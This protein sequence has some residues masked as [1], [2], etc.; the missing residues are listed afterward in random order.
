MNRLLIRRALVDRELK[1]ILIEGESIARIA[2]RIDAAAH[3]DAELVDADGLALLPSLVNAHGHAPMTLLRGIAEDLDLMTWLTR[4]IWPREARLTAEDIYWGLRLAALE[5]IR[6]G[7]TISNEMYFDPR[8]Q[9]R[10]ARDSG[11]RFVVAYPLI[12]GL[13]EAKGAAQRKE[14]AA[15]FDELPDFGP[16]VVFGTAA[17]SVYATSA[18]SLRWL[19]RF[20]RERD[21]FL[22]VHLAETRTED[23]DCRAAHGV[24]PAAYLHELGVLGPRTVAAHGLWL[25]A[26]DF[27]LLAATG[28]V[29]AH[30]PV[31]NMKLA[32]GPAFD[33]EAARARGIRV[34]LGT[35]GA[36]SNNGLNLF[37][38]MKIAGLLQKQHYGD[39]KRFPVAEILAAASTRGHEFFRTGGGRVVEGAAAD[40]I[41][42]DLRS[43][44]AT[45]N[46]DLAANLV[47]ATVT[48]DTTICAGKVLMRRGQIEGAQEV[49]DQVR[50]RA[51]ALAAAV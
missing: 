44:E 43:A 26:R 50:R 18:E 32:S 39:P 15:F 41:L 19:G 22:H 36:A 33:Y 14:C 6:G 24:S 21:L 30:N 42:V 12:D 48:V 31:S 28:T 11:L 35:D 20:T 29:I 5:M 27:D 3:P 37:A 7:I 45:P 23:A 8:A 13:D 47:Y 4:E 40:L 16:R 51:A 9:A 49:I 10:A 25:D 38:D 1:D 34:L 17:H 2:D 46:H